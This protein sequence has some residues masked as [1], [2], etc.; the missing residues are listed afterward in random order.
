[1]CE[2]CKDKGSDMGQLAL[3]LFLRKIE[4]G[5]YKLIKEEFNYVQDL[6]RIVSSDKL[7]QIALLIDRLEDTGQEDGGDSDAA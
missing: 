4:Y 1:M 3:N 7:S 6:I 5:E 2:N